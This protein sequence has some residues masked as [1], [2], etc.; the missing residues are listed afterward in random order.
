MTEGFGV[1]EA[2]KDRGNAAFSA[3]WLGFIC[4]GVCWVVGL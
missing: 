1:G 4:C 2:I 3:A